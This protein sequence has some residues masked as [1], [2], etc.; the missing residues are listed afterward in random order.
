MTRDDVTVVCATRG[1]R[2]AV[3]LTFSS[4][5]RYNPGPWRVFVADNG[6]TD[7]TLEDL[8]ARPEL[9]VVSLPQR[10]ALMRRE[11]SVDRAALALLARRAPALVDRFDPAA[12]D[13]GAVDPA[14]ADPDAVDPGAV[15]PEVEAE[16]GRTLDWLIGRVR[17]PFTLVLDS[18]VQFLEEGCVDGMLALARSS[19]LSALGVHEPGYAGYRPRLAPYVL[20]LRTDVVRRLGVSFR[21]GEVTEDAAERARWQA[22]RPAY[23]LDPAELARFPTTRVYSTGALLF[24]RL[25]EAGEPWADLPVVLA[26][27]FHHYGHLSWGGL[28][29]DDGGN[30]AARA[31]HARVLAAVEQALAAYA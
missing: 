5:A 2:P 23:E 30:A 11:R 1:A 15:D 6:S 17:T 18:D 22:R 20:L 25:L 10:L 31:E 9:Q 12:A 3:R 29:D 13:P 8:R 26:R 16:H 19:G 14:A 24:E 28:A 27:R 4:F 21:G 7:G